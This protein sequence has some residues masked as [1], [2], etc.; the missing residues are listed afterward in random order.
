MTAVQQRSEE[1]KSLK[2]VTF[3]C[4]GIRNKIDDVIAMNDTLDIELT[5]ATETWHRR[6]C[7]TEVR[8]MLVAT[9]PAEPVWVNG[10]RQHHGIAALVGNDRLG[11]AYN[12]LRGTDEEGYAVSVDIGAMTI[13]GVYLPYSMDVK[14]FPRVFRSFTDGMKDDKPFVITGDFNARHVDFG[15]TKTFPKGRWVK[16]WADTMGMYIVAP[17][18]WTF[19]CT[20]NK[21]TSIVDIAIMNGAARRLLK[22]CTVLKEDRFGS[23]HR[24]VLFEFDMQPERHAPTRIPMHKITRS[25]EMVEL[26]RDQLASM[27][28]DVRDK[29]NRFWNGEA[30][31]IQ[32]LA[33]DAY[34]S[35]AHWMVSTAEG[36]VQL[37][38]KKTK[39]INTPEMMTMKA[40]RREIQKFMET[41]R[42]PT[43]LAELML[44][45]KR[46][47][48]RIGAL[49]AAHKQQQFL[50]FTR[51]IAGMDPGEA[52]KTMKSI[53][54]GTMRREKPTVTP[55]RV[56][57]C[58]NHFAAN[59]GST[60]TGLEAPI[61]ASTSRQRRRWAC[62]S[63][64]PWRIKDVVTSL[65][66]GKAPGGSRV[67]AEMMKAGG[68]DVCAILATLLQA[69]VIHNVVPS[70]WRKAIICPVPKKGTDSNVSNF[71][72]ISLTEIPRKVLERILS[73]HIMAGMRPLSIY[74]GGF[75]E[76]RGCPDQ[77]ATLQERCLKQTT[78]RKVIMSFLDIKAAYDTVDRKI[79]WQRCKAYG[80][81][82]DMV[83]ILSQLFDFNWAVVQVV[84]ATSSEIQLNRGLL[85]GSVLSPLLYSIF[86]DPLL[87]KLS[88]MT[89]ERMGTVPLSVIAY[90]DDLALVH[91]N[92][93]TM[94]LMLDECCRFATT[95]NFSFA[96]AKCEFVTAQSGVQLRMDGHALQ[97]VEA[98]TYLGV[99][100]GPKGIIVEQL[101]EKNFTRTLNMLGFLNRLG[102]NGS[103]FDVT[104]KSRMLK[105]FVRSRLEYCLAV[106][107]MNKGQIEE[108][109][110]KLRLMCRMALSF[111][112][113]GMSADAMLVLLDI[114]DMATRYMSL[115][116]RFIAATRAKDAT[117]LVHHAN[118]TQT[119][120]RNSCLYMD[121]EMNAT[122][123]ALEEEVDFL[124]KERSLQGPAHRQ[125]MWRVASRRWR[126][127]RKDRKIREVH[128]NKPAIGFGSH[129]L[130]SHMHRSFNPKSITNVIRFMMKCW[131]RKPTDCLECGK[132]KQRE[133]HFEKHVA[134]PFKSRAITELLQEAA[135][136]AK[137][138]AFN[139]YPHYQMHAF[140]C[141]TN[142]ERGMESQ[143]A[144]WERK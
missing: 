133:G 38:P 35:F 67:S 29:V 9:A 95:N 25:Q 53:C 121:G 135:G 18:E 138:K 114:E 130:L 10:T 68:I 89:T 44:L 139:D 13:V 107:N 27:E 87:V 7:K 6:G 131:P 112:K 117:Y 55:A 21:G 144:Y 73:L 80:I 71:R 123:V 124:M 34:N 101:V 143:S 78:R 136:I 61:S 77:V 45:Q 15:D 116:C 105:C 92:A 127:R 96:P 57:E 137:S 54:N 128:A 36:L 142:A 2:I 109:E 70:C 69:V 63:I 132:K 91:T 24:P 93:K 14:N 75:R 8:N 30:G 31:D 5:M 76:H 3:N 4:N 58:R 74:Q 59:F 23:D 16:E 79:L 22:R 33:D 88:T 37:Q 17:E 50:D 51:N 12:W 120:K 47:V 20:S 65:P 126:N 32:V 125:D 103:G 115:R 140:S 66:N 40:H 100:F 98:F 85:Q 134:V 94:Q 111:S 64:T 46:V 1:P 41:A 90:A 108:F 42:D 99:P 118:A 52:M 43:T 39:L 119:G 72:P 81:G 141:V 11:P 82:D 62:R 56:E 102:L 19:M 49:T 86:I 28:G 97:Q 129:K 104:T 60:H 26:Y 113:H 83:N 106:V 84:G 48:E 122:F 110:K